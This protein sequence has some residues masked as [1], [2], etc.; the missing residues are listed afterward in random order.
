MSEMDQQMG[1]LSA[2]VEELRQDVTE[3]KETL[4]EIIEA[5]H[6]WRGIATTLL[7]LGGIAGWLIDHLAGIAPR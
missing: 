1:A 5:F 7:V 6:R 2:H 3:L 4:K